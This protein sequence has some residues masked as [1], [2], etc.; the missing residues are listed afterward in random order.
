ME[1]ENLTL[2]LIKA[3]TAISEWLVGYFGDGNRKNAAGA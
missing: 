2:A 1:K 3:I